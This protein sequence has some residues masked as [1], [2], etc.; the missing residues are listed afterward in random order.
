MAAGPSC[1]MMLTSAHGAIL[2]TE[3]PHKRGL[4]L[5]PGLGCRSCPTPTGSTEWV[6][7]SACHHHRA[8]A[9]L[10]SLAPPAPLSQTVRGWA[11]STP[12]LPTGTWPHSIPQRAHGKQTPEAGGLRDPRGALRDDGVLDELQ[13]PLLPQDPGHGDGGAQRVPQPGEGSSPHH[14]QA[15]GPD[16]AL[17]AEG[18]I[19]GEILLETLVQLQREGTLLILIRYPL[20][21]RSPLDCARVP[22]HQPG[23][24]A[25][26]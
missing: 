3:Q 2:Y 24:K 15:Q 1:S 21:Q 18:F 8:E 26:S 11:P 17:E 12:H 6:P 7:T 25:S 20:S 9:R 4:G 13:Q 5:A 16:A 23:S 10:S 22:S 19:D 14:V